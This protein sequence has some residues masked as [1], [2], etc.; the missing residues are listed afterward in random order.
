VS[1]VRVAM[2]IDDDIMVDRLLI[3]M[4]RRRRGKNTLSMALAL[5][6][7]CTQKVYQVG[8]EK[9]RLRFYSIPKN[10]MNRAFFIPKPFT[11]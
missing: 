8:A 4:T 7:E 9:S 1:I 3:M 11:E 10:G 5:C 2:I 6:V